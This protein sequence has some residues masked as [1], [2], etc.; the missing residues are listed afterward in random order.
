MGSL[1]VHCVC[2]NKIQD[3]AKL[4]RLITLIDGETWIGLLGAFRLKRLKPGQVPR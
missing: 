2:Q 4:R 3:P 1:F